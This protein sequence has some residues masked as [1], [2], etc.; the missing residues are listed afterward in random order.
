MLTLALM[1]ALA[2]ASAPSLLED[3]KTRTG[4]WT[5]LVP[6]LVRVSLLW[7]CVCVCVRAGGNHELKSGSQRVAHDPEVAPFGNLYKHFDSNYVSANQ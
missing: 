6:G 2:L 3:L 1:L 5:E 4:V 7:C